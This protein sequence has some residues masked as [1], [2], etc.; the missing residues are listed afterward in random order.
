MGL[1][2]LN[3][4]VSGIDDP[5]TVDPRTWYVT[6]YDC[7]GNVVEHCGRRYVVLPAKCGHL[8][9]TLPPGCYRVTAVWGFTVVK[10]GLVYHANHFTDSAIV[11]VC[12]NQMTCVKLFN[13]SAHRCGFIY[14]RA[15][16]D[17]LAQKAIPPK[18]VEAAEAA[19][20]AINKHLGQPEKPFE[21]GHYEEIVKLV[22]KQ[23]KPS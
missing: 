15:L 13:P 21:L 16:H 7:D 3:V 8:E 11:Q 12:C 20:T 9:V 14:L 19:I 17:L 2:T 22:K 5:C 1:A 4:F 18:L 23:E 6:I 10:P